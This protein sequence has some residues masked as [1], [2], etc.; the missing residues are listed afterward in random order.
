VYVDHD[1]GRFIRDTLGY[2]SLPVVLVDEQCHFA[3]YRPEPLD[4]FTPP[5]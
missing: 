5:H 4:L 2:S 3:G 1:A